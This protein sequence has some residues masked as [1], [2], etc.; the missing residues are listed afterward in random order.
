MFSLTH[1]GSLEMPF[2]SFEAV[3]SFWQGQTTLESL[4]PMLAVN[5][6]KALYPNF[7]SCLIR[8]APV[9]HNYKQ[10][11]HPVAHD[12]AVVQMWDVSHNQLATLQLEFEGV[13]TQNS[14]FIYF[15]QNCNTN[16]YITMVTRK[17]RQNKKNEETH[18]RSLPL[19][20]LQGT[21]FPSFPHC[22][23][24]SHHYLKMVIFFLSEIQNTKIKTWNKPHI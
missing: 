2:L 16:S 5:N 19:G 13:S 17:K 22:T 15:T 6:W 10:Q 3:S 1:P 11:T 12:M 9:M 8:I 21:T 18:Q 14:E 7:S 24:C 4:F 20:P 23:A